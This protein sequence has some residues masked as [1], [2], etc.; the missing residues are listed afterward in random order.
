MIPQQREWMKWSLCDGTARFYT[1][2][3]QPRVLMCFSGNV[4]ADEL[5]GVH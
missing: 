4:Y 5:S 2:E 1:K 3:V